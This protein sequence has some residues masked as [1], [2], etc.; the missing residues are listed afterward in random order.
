[1]HVTKEV[2]PLEQLKDM[3]DDPNTCTAHSD[4]YEVEGYKY[5]TIYMLPYEMYAHNKSWYLTHHEQYLI[6]Y[7]HEM[8]HCE[9]GDWH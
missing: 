6:S 1:M 9:K 5:C 8:E 3:C 7:G 4:W 2:V